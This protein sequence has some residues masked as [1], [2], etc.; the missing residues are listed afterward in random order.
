MNRLSNRR[1][2]LRFLLETASAA[3]LALPAHAQ[4]PPSSPGV[5]FKAAERSE[6]PVIRPKLAIFRPRRLEL[7]P[8]GTGFAGKLEVGSQEQPDFLG[9]R[10]ERDEKTHGIN[11]LVGGKT[12]ALQQTDKNASA[13]VAPWTGSLPVTVKN[14]GKRV[15]A[16]LSVT[17]LPEGNLG[18][19]AGEAPL[20]YHLTAFTGGSL[21]LGGLPYRAALF[22][23]SYRGDFRGRTDS[24]ATGTLLLLDVN[25]NGSFDVRGEAFD[26]GQ[27]FTVHGVTYEIK[28]VSEDGTEFRVQK[29]AKSV[30][31]I[32]PPPDLSPGHAAP[33]FTVTTLDGKKVKF[34]GDYRGKLVMLIFWASWCGD[35]RREVPFFTSA[36]QK[37]HGRGLEALGISLDQAGGT[38]GLKTYLKENRMTW[39]QGYTGGFWNDPAAYLYGID[40]I[41][42]FVLVDGDTGKIAASGENLAALKMES[43][44]SAAMEQKFGG[45]T[46]K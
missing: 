23:T 5:K 44:L 11:L 26:T 9:V 20:F 15:S 32:L 17:W 46:K 10:I 25:G 36:Y 19:G 38:E 37:W 8:E 30:P 40:W 34:P 1:Y 22:D 4:P 29:S 42:T 39:A 7:T 35:C 24:P 21:V 14:G 43:T 13:S 41:P 16:L 27:P 6:L 33:P 3:L 2:L 31:E 28:G 18:R 45:Q 12:A